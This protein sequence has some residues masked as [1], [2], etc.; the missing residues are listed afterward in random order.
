[1]LNHSDVNTRAILMQRNILPDRV[2]KVT[3][4]YVNTITFNINIA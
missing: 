3:S 2:I 4:E 1:M